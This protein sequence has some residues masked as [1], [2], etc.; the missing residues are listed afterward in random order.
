LIVGSQISSEALHNLARSGQR[1][2][3]IETRSN[4]PARIP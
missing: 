4:S 3:T 1:E 2:I